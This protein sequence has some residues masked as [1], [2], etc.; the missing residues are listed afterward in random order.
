M[1]VN[2]TIT[3]E[4]QFMGRDVA[5][6]L[7]RGCDW[8]FHLH[9]LQQSFVAVGY[10][11]F[12]IYSKQPGFQCLKQFN[13]NVPQYPYLLDPRGGGVKLLVTQREL[14]VVQPS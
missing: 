5:G 11:G 10:S 6:F 1:F 3:Q 13:F 2:C 7:E 9:A 12:A 14:K 8:A 4:E